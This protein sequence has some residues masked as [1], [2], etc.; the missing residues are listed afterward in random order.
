MRSKEGW[1]R[2]RE[3]HNVTQTVRERYER[4]QTSENKA[5]VEELLAIAR[6]AALT[7]KPLISTTLS[8]SMTSAG[9]RNVS[10]SAPPHFQKRIGPRCTRI[11]LN[12][13]YPCPS[14]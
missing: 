7:S 5:S 11:N 13:L 14:V 9:S 10:S 12:A 8:F 3:H 4:L 6:R 1:G 2:K